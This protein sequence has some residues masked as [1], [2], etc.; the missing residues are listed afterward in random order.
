MGKAIADNAAKAQKGASS[1]TAVGRSSTYAVDTTA[2]RKSTRIFRLNADMSMTEKNQILDAAYVQ[3]MDV[4]SG[5]I[6][7]ELRRLDLDAQ[8]LNGTLSVREFVCAL[9]S[10]DVYVRR[11]YAPYPNTKA[12]E[13]LCL[14]LLGRTLVNP[15]EVSHYNKILT[16]RG[17]S[18]AV[19]A[20]VDS[21]EYHRYF[22]EDV[23]PYNR[24][25]LSISAHS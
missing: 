10:S 9:A 6:P 15:D 11:F 21:P 7:D 14:H 22:G 13:L 5:Q 24:Y 19:Q 2:Q 25:P 16:D 3:I 23:V 1:L 4:V 18:S 20:M 17:L 8:L 12:I